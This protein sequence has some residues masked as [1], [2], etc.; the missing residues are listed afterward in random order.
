PP[1]APSP[2][3]RRGYAETVFRRQAQGTKFAMSR[4]HRYS[5]FP[6]LR[7]L[8]LLA[9]D[10]QDFF[11]RRGCSQALPNGAVVQKFGDGSEGA[12]MCLELVL[13]DNEED[14]EFHRRVIERV[15]LNT[16]GRTPKGGYHFVQPVG[17]TVRNG[18]AKP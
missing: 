2:A 5:E 14:D 3:L 9:T 10:G 17:R 18:D 11:A 16:S 12:Q 8:R 13:R 15:E 4:R 6:G 7:L 1:A